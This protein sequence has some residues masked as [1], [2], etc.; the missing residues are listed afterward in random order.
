MSSIVKNAL[1]YIKDKECASLNVQTIAA[2]VGVT[3]EHLSRLFHKDCGIQI[4]QYLS[5]LRIEMCKKNLLVKPPQNIQEVALLSGFKDA[6][7]FSRFF[8]KQT[9]LTPTEF[10]KTIS[11]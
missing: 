4:L 8:K 9:G 11:K 5:N 10:K 7:Y 2:Y 1:Q 6:N 3:H